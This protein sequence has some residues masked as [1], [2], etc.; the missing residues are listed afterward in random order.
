MNA[1]VMAAVRVT[2]GTTPTPIVTG[3]IGASWVYLHA[4]SGGNTVFIGGADV[5]TANGMELPKGAIYN[6]WVPENQTLYGI[7]GSSTQPLMTLISGGA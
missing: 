6:L 3:R 2:I 4:P 1:P 7:V 5:T